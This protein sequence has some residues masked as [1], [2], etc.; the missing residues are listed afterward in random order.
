MVDWC[1]GCLA[2]GDLVP[3]KWGFKMRNLEECGFWTSRVLREDGQK[4]HGTDA[5]DRTLSGQSCD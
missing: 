1:I 3:S 5:T 2:E 4:V